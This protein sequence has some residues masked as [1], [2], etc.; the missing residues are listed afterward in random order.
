MYKI[1][2]IIKYRMGFEV[3]NQPKLVNK[4]AKTTEPII[5]PMTIHRLKWPHRE[6][7]L[8]MAFPIKGSIASSTNRK[9]AIIMVIQAIICVP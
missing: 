5:P 8:S 3:F 4:S 9:P 7:V 2:K 1:A 6:L